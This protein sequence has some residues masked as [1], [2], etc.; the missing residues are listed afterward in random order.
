MDG[1]NGERPIHYAKLLQINIKDLPDQMTIWEHLATNEDYDII[2]V[3][4]T[5]LLLPNKTAKERIWC[6]HTGRKVVL[7]LKKS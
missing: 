1:R 5:S 2:S 7:F 3:Y 6:R 4:G